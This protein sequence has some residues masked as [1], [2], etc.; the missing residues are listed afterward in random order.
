MST[1]DCDYNGAQVDC[2]C[3][4]YAYEEGGADAI[5][6]LINNWECPACGYTLGYNNTRCLICTALNERWVYEITN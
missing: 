5:T 6:A 3:K 2:E 1:H 4:R